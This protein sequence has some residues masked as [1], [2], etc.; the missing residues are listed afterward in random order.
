MSTTTDVNDAF[1]AERRE[2]IEYAMGAAER[3]QAQ[4]EA[5]AARFDERVAEGTLRNLGNGRFQ[6]TDPGSFDNGE[7]LTLREVDVE[8]IKQRMVLP[9]HGLDTTTGQVAL[10]SKVPVWHELG[11]VI[12]GGLTDIDEVLRAGGLAWLVEKRPDTY[13]N[14]VTGKEEVLDGKFKTYRMDTGKALGVVGNIYDAMQNRES[15]EFLEALVG[16]FGVVWESAGALRD[17]AR[18]FVSMRLPESIVIDV[19]G[20]QDE[21]IPFVVALNS[22]D[23]SGKFEVIVTPWRPVCGNTERFAI[24]DAHVRWGTRHTTNARDKVAEARYTFAQSIKYFEQF[25]R[26]EELLAQTPFR[27]SDLEALIN[28]IWG[29]VDEDASKRAQTNRGKLL[30]GVAALH[31]S[32][33]ATLGATA[34]A[35]ER[36]L[37]EWADW[38]RNLKPR[39]GE[40]R[41]NN[42]A[43]RATA[44][45]EDTAGDFKTKAH[46][47]LMLRTN[48]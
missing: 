47:Q 17:G 39:S 7:I 44:V 32:N 34:Y 35:A 30:E 33:V 28:E 37:T 15:F 40:L 20:V 45:L 48:R 31:A 43:A 25:A 2:Q 41:G 12:P 8:G 10:Y 27:Q 9:E 5:R 22:H 16:K 1:A 4:N 13:R 38:K 24:R 23:G 3:A 11:T 36:T 26:E 29:E 6:V 18:T 42:L 46:R 21:I 19:N 14:L